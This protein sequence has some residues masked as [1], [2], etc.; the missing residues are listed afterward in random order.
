[1]SISIEEQFA[2]LTK[3]CVDVVRAAE[4]RAKLA[5]AAETAAPLKGKDVNDA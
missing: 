1:M 3:G 5:R 2:Y 4:L